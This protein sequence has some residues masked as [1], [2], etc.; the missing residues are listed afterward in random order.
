MNTEESKE[1]NICFTIIGQT[2]FCVTPCG[3]SFCF[4][5]IMQSIN[6]RN[7]CPCCRA[8]LYQ[9]IEGL[10]EDNDSVESDLS[11][12]YEYMVSPRIEN[13]PLVIETHE[14]LVKVIRRM[15]CVDYEL[16]VLGIVN[17]VD[18]DDADW[19]NE[20]MEDLADLAENTFIETVRIFQRTKLLKRFILG[21]LERARVIPTLGSV[22]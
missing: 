19:D 22:E 6:Y 7:T 12:D 15:G 13:P 4:D 10:D 11:S 8:D 16:W 21:Y 1:C 20:T 3:H 17:L 9:E 2:N 14:E 5:C 18:G